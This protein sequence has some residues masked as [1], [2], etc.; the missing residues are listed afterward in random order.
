[1]IDLA[2]TGVDDKIPVPT[3]FALEQNYPNPFNPL[4][5]IQYAVPSLPDGQ[6]GSQ[7][8]SLKVYNMLGQQV[9]E[10]V[11]GM[12]SPGYKSVEWDASKMPSGVYF[13]R[14]HAGTFTSIKKMLLTK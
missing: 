7:Y 3:K 14:L 10:L 11:N 12:Q 4:T 9:A 13:Y 2:V 6:A 8:I 1:M 5:R